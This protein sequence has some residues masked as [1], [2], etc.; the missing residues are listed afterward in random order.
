MLAGNYTFFSQ[1]FNEIFG[2]KC[3]GCEDLEWMSN[4]VPMELIMVII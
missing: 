4:S 2:S 3:S 1:V